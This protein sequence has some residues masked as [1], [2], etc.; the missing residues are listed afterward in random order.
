[1]SSYLMLC[2][3]QVLLNV[4]YFLSCYTL[5]F[6]LDRKHLPLHQKQLLVVRVQL[7]ILNMTKQSFYEVGCAPIS[8]SWGPALWSQL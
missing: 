3:E 8:A 1:M 2:F 6:L 5:G 7:I 4:E